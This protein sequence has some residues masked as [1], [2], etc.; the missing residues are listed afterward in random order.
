MIKHVNFL[1]RTINL[2]FS[3]LAIPIFHLIYRGKK[4]FRRSIKINDHSDECDAQQKIA[5]IF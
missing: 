2:T 1:I 3:S 4:K 5:A